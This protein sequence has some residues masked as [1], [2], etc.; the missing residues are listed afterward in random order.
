[1]KMNQTNMERLRNW[2]WP[3]NS[4]NSSNELYNP[5]S[6]RV[7]RNRQLFSEKKMWSQK[8]WKIMLVMVVISHIIMRMVSTVEK[9]YDISPIFVFGKKANLDY[10]RDHSNLTYIIC[11]LFGKS[12]KI[13][14]EEFLGDLRISPIPFE[15]TEI[16]ILAASLIVPFK[17]RWTYI[18][19]CSLCILLLTYL[20]DVSLGENQ[21]CVVWVTQIGIIFSTITLNPGVS[22]CIIVIYSFDFGALIH[23]VTLQWFINQNIIKWWCATFFGFIMVRVLQRNLYR[24]WELTHICLILRLRTAG[25][26]KLPED[27]ARVRQN[28]STV[29]PYILFTREYILIPSILNQS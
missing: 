3:K 25:V 17:H 6:N 21:G 27:I 7:Q 13:L 1:V 15:V 16:V 9:A 14:Q 8:N 2:V 26:K 11:Y 10:Y 28:I 12:N 20:T 4:S 29:C 5:T 18:V 23:G 19:V 22:I 24:Q